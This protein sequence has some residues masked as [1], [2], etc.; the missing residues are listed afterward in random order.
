MRVDGATGILR[1]GYQRAADVGAWSIEPAGYRKTFRLTAKIDHINEFWITRTPL[2]AVMRVAGMNWI[3]RDI[4]I[5]QDK[6]SFTALLDGTP[7]VERL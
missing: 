7:I 2:D 1:V 5:A 6:G 4:S 3:W